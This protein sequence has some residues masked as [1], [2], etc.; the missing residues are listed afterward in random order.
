MAERRI[1]GQGDSRAYAL[2]LTMIP[3]IGDV[4]ARALLDCL[5]TAQAIFCSSLRQLMRV[6]G[7][8]RK[9]AEAIV[10]F[11]DW[12]LVEQEL[13]F[14]DA[15]QI[16]MIF[17]QDDAYPDRLRVLP[18]APIVV[19][20]RGRV[21][22]HAARMV[23]VVGTRR[24]TE[25][26]RQ[27][28]QRIVEGLRN[29]HVSIV[30]GL[31]YGIDIAAHQAAI[32]NNMPTIAVLAHGLQRIY[33]LRHAGIA[34]TMEANGGL[35]TEF[36]SVDAFEPQNFP[37]R[38]RLIAGLCDAT[39]VVETDIAGGAVITAQLANSYGRDVFCV[40]G[41]T[42][43]RCS[44]GC[45]FLIRTQRAMLIESAE[46]IANTLEWR[47]EPHAKAKQGKLFDDLTDAEKEVLQLLAPGTSLHV[48]QISAVWSHPPNEL[49]I[50]L[51]QLELKGLIVSLPGKVFRRK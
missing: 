29:Y 3:G 32:N 19:F 45:N 38:N 17:I 7:I 46:D 2:A 36:K 11:G 23:A 26:G 1:S 8:S 6:P 40:P 16:Q 41:R 31:A 15:H 48:D 12:K 13:A 10:S 5:G 51:L 47:A 35:L 18:D 37:L 22:L 9:R 20:A 27:M 24:C 39:V 4:L 21:D 33:P 43:D 25:Y 34:R 28:T 14:I 50:C 30:S 44:R 42:G 49:A